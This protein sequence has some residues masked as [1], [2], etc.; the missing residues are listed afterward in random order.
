MLIKFS[1]SNYRSFHQTQEISMV[2]ST[3]IKEDL[4]E[5]NAFESGVKDIRLLKSAA[6]YGANAS[7]KTNLLKAFSFMGAFVSGALTAKKGSPIPVET[8]LLNSEAEKKPT[9]FEIIFIQNNIRYDY[10]FSVTSERVIHESLYGY[11]SG[12]P[13]K[14]FERNFVDTN[15][16]KI[17]FE[18]YDYSQGT[19][20]RLDKQ[21]IKKTR[22]DV[23]Y[24]S[25]AAFFNN[26]EIEPIHEWFIKRATVISPN[27]SYPVSTAKYCSNEEGKNRVLSLLKTADIAIKDIEVV[28]Q[29]FAGVK[30]VDIKFIRNQNDTDNEVKTDFKYHESEGTKQYFNLIYYWID[31]LENGYV[32]VIDELDDHLHPNLLSQ[33]I[34]LFHNPEYNKKGA[35]LIF[36]THATHLMHANLLRR[37]QIWFTQKND[38]N[39]S[40]LYSLAEFKGVRIGEAIERNYLRGKYGATPLLGEPDL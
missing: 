38:H 31:A 19:S 1:V 36:T 20:H 7:G 21:I 17:Y 24:F 9:C 13:E 14:Y 6:I 10:R 28:W 37:D 16:S 29:Q 2:A 12:R 33:L 39:E 8:F 4:L 32:L 5:E 34:E 30:G 3:G 35:Q 22:S 40:E 23:L 11:P 15:V 25:N 18:N 26:K 27:N